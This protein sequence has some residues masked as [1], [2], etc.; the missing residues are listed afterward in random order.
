MKVTRTDLHQCYS[1]IS[2]TVIR[3]SDK[4]QAPT[5]TIWIFGSLCTVI[6]GLFDIKDLA[7]LANSGSLVAFIMVSLC[8]ILLRK[9]HPELNKEGFKVPFYPV[10][11]VLS[12]LACLFLLFSL[13]LFTWGY[14]IIWIVVAVVNYFLS[15]WVSGNERSS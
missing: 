11:P 13:P 3:T 7:H 9:K 6:T 10:L 12:V 15:R 8:T 14:L 5:L 1:P 4:T 2:F